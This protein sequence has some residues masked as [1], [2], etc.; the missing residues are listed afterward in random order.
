MTKT[1]AV[2]ETKAIKEGD[3]WVVVNKFFPSSRISYELSQAELFASPYTT[4][5]IEG[6]QKG[7]AKK[8]DAI[9]KAREVR[10]SS[11]WFEGYDEMYGIVADDDE[12]GK[13]GNT[14]NQLLKKNEPDLPWHSEDLQNYDNDE[15]NTIDVMRLSAYH[16]EVEARNNIVKRAFEKEKKRKA[17]STKRGRKKQK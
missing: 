9:V 3:H 16:T 10:D 5:K 2:K 4:M 1:K 6:P 15:E 13:D 11:C 12:N 14:A 17:S 7:F 8:E